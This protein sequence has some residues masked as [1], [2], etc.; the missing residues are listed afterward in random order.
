MSVFVYPI[1]GGEEQPGLGPLNANVLSFQPQAE[2]KEIKDK[3]RARRGQ[4]QAAVVDPQTTT[5]EIEFNSVPAKVMSLLTLGSVVER[6]SAGGTVTGEAVTVTEDFWTPLENGNVSS[7]SVVSGVQATLNTG[8][9]GNNNALTWTALEPGT[10]GNSI[11][12]KLTDPGTTASLSVAVAGTDINVNLAYATGAI[13]STA[14]QV[15]AAIEASAEASALVTVAHTSTSTGAAAV[16]AV[17]KTSLASGAASGGTTYTEDEDYELETRLGQIRPLVGGG[18]GT[19]AFVSYTHGA[20]TGQRIEVGTN[21]TTRARIVG[22]G[23]NDVTGDDFEWEAY[24]A[25]LTPNGAIDLM[26]DDPL[27]VK[28]SAAFETPSGKDHPI[29]MDWPVYA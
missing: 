1:I 24:S 6:S 12:V 29:R 22:T 17:A 9:V 16:V 27:T 23:T 19:Y 20:V 25:L 14:A 18:M 2:R 8:V 7:V 11:T 15:K 28:F 5:G 10:G 26:S 13:T 21:I 4:V 3:R